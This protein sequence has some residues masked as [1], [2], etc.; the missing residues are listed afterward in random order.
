MCVGLGIEHGRISRSHFRPAQD[1]LAPV[2]AALNGM[3]GLWDVRAPAGNIFFPGLVYL[4]KTWNRVFS[5]AFL[6]PAR[7]EAVDAFSRFLN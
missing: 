6:P 2:P 1:G 5:E 7:K 3:L 4:T